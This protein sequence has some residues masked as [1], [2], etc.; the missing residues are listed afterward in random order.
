MTKKIEQG[1]VK[2][3]MQINLGNPDEISINELANEIILFSKKKINKKFLP[4]TENDPKKRK[5]DIS[6]AIS[7]LGWKPKISRKVGI[8]KTFEYFRSLIKN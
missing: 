6:K 8:K 5:P 2:A 4:L 3:E 1:W 7:K